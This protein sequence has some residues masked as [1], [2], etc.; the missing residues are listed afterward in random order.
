MLAEYT[1]ATSRTWTGECLP[2]GW[3]GEPSHPPRAP[4]SGCRTSG[5]RERSCPTG[6]DLFR[7]IPT[8]IQV[9][10]LTFRAICDALCPLALVSKGASPRGQAGELLRLAVRLNRPRTGRAFLHGHRRCPPAVDSCRRIDSIVPRLSRMLCWCDSAYTDGARPRDR[11][12]EGTGTLKVTGLAESR[13]TAEEAPSRVILSPSYSEHPA[14]SSTS[15][16]FQV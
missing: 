2:D 9:H 7:P 15:E 14:D 16:Y 11:H 12:C 1:L 6:N 3:E 10:V 5:S 13:R 8:T 4:L